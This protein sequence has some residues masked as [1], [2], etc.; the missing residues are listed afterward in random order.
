MADD[1]RCWADSKL[2]GRDESFRTPLSR[3]TSVSLASL[4]SQGRGTADLEIFAITDG[5]HYY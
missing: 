3:P 4:P 5:S 1:K 2:V